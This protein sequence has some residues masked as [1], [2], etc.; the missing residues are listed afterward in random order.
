LAGVLYAMYHIGMPIATLDR[1]LGS[2]DFAKPKQTSKSTH[3]Y[4][5]SRTY[6]CNYL[7]PSQ[8]LLFDAPRSFELW[9]AG[10]F[11]ADDTMIY[12][13]AA[14]VPSTMNSLKL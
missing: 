5:V 6:V 9:G 11:W 4:L 1:F 13:R 7:M 14:N 3:Y 12:L 2:G 8:V 10:D